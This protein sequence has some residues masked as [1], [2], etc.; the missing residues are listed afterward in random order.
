MKSVRF[1]LAGVLLPIFGAANAAQLDMPDF[2][3]LS[4][5]AT[6]AVNITLSPWMLQIAGALIDDKDADAAATKKMLLGIKSIEVHSYQFAT[7]FAYS[8]ADI[9]ALRGQLNGPG[10][11][12]LM[13]VH[14]RDS[15]EDV[16]M[17]VLTDGKQTQGFVL[18]ASEPREVTIIHIVGSIAMQDLPRLQ[19]QLHLPKAVLG[20]SQLLM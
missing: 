16:G 5:K 18:V 4:G 6:D 9:D 10:W 8:A 11:S 20:H 7:D 13:Q 12:S 14:N 17:Y 15:R 1:A 2:H 3:G 19:S